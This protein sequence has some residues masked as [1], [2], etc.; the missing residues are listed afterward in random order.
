VIAGGTGRVTFEAGSQVQWQARART[1]RRVLG[2]PVPAF[3]V[4]EAYD[5]SGTASSAYGQ[6][7]WAATPRLML[8]PGA[9]LD[10]WSLTDDVAG[11]PWLLGDLRLTDTWRL[12]GGA[13]LFRQAPGFDAVSGLRG[14][15]G[16]AHE[17]AYHADIG[18]EQSIGTSARW[19]VTFYNREERDVLRLPDTELRV[20]NGTLTGFSQSSTWVNAL[21]GYARGIELLVQRRSAGGLSGWFSYSYGVNRYRDRTTGEAFDGDYDQRHTFNV[22]A[23]YR[24]SNRTSLAAKFRAGS[25]APATGYWEQRND[26]Y[27][28]STARN[29]LRVPAYSRLDIRGNRTFNWQ[30]KRLTLF[31]ELLNA[32][33]HDNVRFAVPGVNGRTH[34]AFGLFDPLIPFVPSAGILLEF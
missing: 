3:A 11:S 30:G 20:E 17:R 18:L 1:S 23:L 21:E 16:L 15:A 9:R 6:V 31:A 8:S 27:F 29:T 12:R 2:A 19:Q 5:D 14:A 25:N 10:H 26:A 4:L 32:L 33:G 13:G 28:V 7:R 22:Q 24:L 34:Q